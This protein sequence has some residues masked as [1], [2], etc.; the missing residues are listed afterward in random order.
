MKSPTTLVLKSCGLN[1]WVAS[2][3]CGL[4]VQA[5]TVVIAPAPSASAS[6][7]APAPAPDSPPPLPVDA[8]RLL[9]LWFDAQRAYERVPGISAGVVIDQ[10][11]VWSKGYGLADVQRRVPAAPDTV[12]SIGSI[13]KLFTSIAVMQLWEAGKLSLDDDVAKY[14]PLFAIRRHEPREWGLKRTCS[15]LSWALCR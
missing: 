11:L 12:Y 14:L 13:S 8:L 4:S 9:D 7:S 6:A 1:I 10:T 2:L 5:Q 15:A 3:C